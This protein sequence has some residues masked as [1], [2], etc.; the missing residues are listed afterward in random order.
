MG[1]SMPVK[2]EGAVGQV[3]DLPLREEA[4][5]ILARKQAED[6]VERVQDLPLQESER[7]MLLAA[8]ERRNVQ[9]Q[10]AAE[11][12][13]IASSILDVDVLLERSVSLIREYFGFYY[14]GLFLANWEENSAVLRAATG[15]A[16]QAMLARGHRLEM[17]GQSMIGQCIARK[18]ARIAL[19]VEQED[20]R[21]KNPWLPDTRSEIALPLVSR[22]QVLGA[23]T[24]QSKIGAAFSEEDVAVLQTVADQLAN[25]IAN[26]RQ[27]RMIEEARAETEEHARRQALLSEMSRQLNDAA[28][29]YEILD[30]AATQIGRIFAADR[31]SVALLTPAG[32]SFE[33]FALHGEEGAAPVETRVRA[34][35]SEM[36]TAVR[37]RRLILE[38]DDQRSQLGDIRAFMVAPLLVSRRAIGTLNVGSKRPNV[39]TP[40]DGN[41]L[42]QAASLLSSA[43][44]NRRLFEQTQQ[45]LADLTMIQ[46][47]VS[48]LAEAFTLDEAINVLLPQVTGVVQADVVSMFLIEGPSMRRMAVYP[49]GEGDDVQIGQVVSID[50]YPLTKQVIE[51]RRL[52][53][54]VTDDP[55]L[56][57]HARQAFEAAGITA[58]ATIPL[59]G[60]QGVLGT[61]ALGLRQPGRVFTEHELSML[62][63][64]A[65][66]ATLAFEKA[67]LFEETQQQVKELSMLFETSQALSS[68]LL[69]PEGIAEIIAR[70]LVGLGKM[71]C[72]FSLIQPDGDSLQTLADLYVE[73]DGTVRLSDYDETIRLSEYPATAWVI[74]TLQPLAVQAS[75]PQADPAELAYMRKYG[76]ET[77]VIVPLVVKGQAIGVM[78]VESGEERH[79]TWGQI[80]LMRTLASQAAIAIQNTHLFQQAQSALEK[81]QSL[82]Q[83]YLRESWQGYLEARGRAD[84]PVY[85]YDRAQI[86][87]A[88][89]LDSP[90]IDQALARKELIRGSESEGTGQVV[91]VPISLRGQPI[92]ALAIESVQDGRLWGEEEIAL[93]E[94]VATQL[95]L[96]IENARLFEFTQSRARRERLIRDITDKIRGA[97]DLDAILQTTVVE[98]GKVLGTS[99]VAIRLGTEAE[100]TL[101]SDRAGRA[102]ARPAPT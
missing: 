24:V 43:I 29:L 54:L 42:L 71:E 95:A 100:L 81:A 84:Q 13:R 3:Q 76:V 14:V 87:H 52:L 72:S 46:K 91:A 56:Q 31:A 8:L 1:E 94:A 53:A 35:G 48:E 10:T 79:Y 78:E 37:E 80:N 16:G 67:R 17:G 59:V 74:E 64:L 61:L 102:G 89:D 2:G 75:D 21:F 86:V 68:A 33:V 65:D 58:S 83:Q 5:V 23:L 7:G 45:Q 38:F 6:S 34:E 55:R 93:I 85:V 44:E 96:A 20:L 98:L 57:D 39:Y 26:A 18:Q 51:T 30:I 60:R 25:A 50:D 22:D 77:L 15:A 41:L 28:D 36:E 47:T 19:D 73:E 97:T 90:E 82:H 70:Q 92:G 27:F 66:Q 40:H 101:P 11:V 49:V 9:L 4:R 12:S 63:T 88:P 62:Q 99:R 69:G 32:E